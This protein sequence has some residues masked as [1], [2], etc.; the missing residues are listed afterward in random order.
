MI[1]WIV[2]LFWRIVIGDRRDL[3]SDIDREIELSL[4]PDSDPEAPLVCPMCKATH[5]EPCQAW[6]K[7]SACARCGWTLE[8]HY[9]RAMPRVGLFCPPLVP[10]GREPGTTYLARRD[11]DDDAGNG[12]EAA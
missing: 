10:G 3:P 9:V 12:P 4:D 8:H 2:N 7:N 5:H 6:C 1:A 11:F